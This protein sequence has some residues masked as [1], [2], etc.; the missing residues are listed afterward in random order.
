M[1]KYR[2]QNA[3]QPEKDAEVTLNLTPL[4]FFVVGYMAVKALLGTIHHDRAD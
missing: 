2:K 3:L 1:I 4:L